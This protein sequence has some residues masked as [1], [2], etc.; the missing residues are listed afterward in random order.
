MENV[1]VQN[2]VQLAP[3]KA[4]HEDAVVAYLSGRSISCLSA[5]NGH[6][7]VQAS[8]LRSRALLRLGRLADVIDE[9]AST[10]PRFTDHARSAE[11]QFLLGTTLAR[12]GRFDEAEEALANASAYAN[13][14]AEPELITEAAFYRAL[15]AFMAGGVARAH[16][17]ATNALDDRAGSPH[18][19]LLELLGLVAGIQGDVERQIAMHRGALEHVAA[20]ERRDL[21]IEANTLNNLAVPVSEFNPPGYADYVRSRAGA[22]DWNDE[23]SGARF[24]LVHHLAWLDALAGNH[25]SAFRNFRTAIALAP[26]MARR[27]EALAGRGYLARE[28]GETIGA[29]EC[30]ADAEELVRQIDWN[31]TD[32]DERLALLQLAMLVAPLHSERAAAYVE[33]YKAIPKKINRLNVAAHG[34]PLYRAKEAH[35]FGLVAKEHLGPA[36]AVPLLQTAHDLFRSVSSGWRAAVVAMDLYDAARDPAML[37]YARE[38]AVRIPQSW[39]ARRVARL[40]DLTERSA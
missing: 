1:I 24:H 26:T 2:V 33:R 29:S 12:S 14:S 31:K 11:H 6:E 15:A 36:F 16:E 18:A 25:L 34:D 8:L 27:A 40:T 7:G 21:Y 35:A 38:H 4:A 13:S 22:I 17:I 28:M 19:R 23:L 37:Q 39:L 32:D 5:L 9:L 20:I 3:R 30:V 10:I